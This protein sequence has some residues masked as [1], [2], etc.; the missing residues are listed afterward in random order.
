SSSPPRTKPTKYS[1]SFTAS[2]NAGVGKSA[3]TNSKLDGAMATAW[4]TISFG[5]MLGVKTIRGTGT[6]F[7]AASGPLRDDH[8]GR[9]ADRERLAAAIG[10][11][12]LA[13]GDRAPV[14]QDPAF[15]KDLAVAHAG[16]VAHVQIERRLGHAAFRGFAQRP[17]RPADRHVDERAV[18]PAVHGRAGRV[19]DLVADGHAQPDPPGLRL[20]HAH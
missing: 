7:A 13:E 15:G 10:N 20:D 17:E 12:H 4:S 2:M 16:E 6:P 14:A 5:R 18:D 8:V 9:A 11:R 19:L 3:T 1:A